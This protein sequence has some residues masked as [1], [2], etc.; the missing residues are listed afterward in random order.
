MDFHVQ[1]PDGSFETGLVNYPSGTT[2]HE[3]FGPPKKVA[4]GDADH[5]YAYETYYTISLGGRTFRSPSKTVDVY[6]LWIN[7]FRDD[8]TGKAW[9]V[10]VGD[11]IAYDAIAA[12]KVTN[13]A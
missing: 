13:W 1:Q 10:T 5:K 9:K 7:S 6:E 11:A 4:D 12:S 3:L 8:A 2:S